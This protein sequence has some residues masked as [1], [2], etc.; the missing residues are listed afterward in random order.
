MDFRTAKHNS[1]IFLCYIWVYIW[2]VQVQIE[3]SG[4]KKI[5]FPEKKKSSG[6]LLFHLSTVGGHNYKS[7]CT[8]REWDEKMPRYSKITFTVKVKWEN[9][10]IDVAVKRPD[11]TCEVQAPSSTP[12]V[13]A[14]SKLLLGIG[15]L[16]FFS[17]LVFYLGMCHGLLQMC[18]RG[19]V[20]FSQQEPAV[21]WKGKERK[22]RLQSALSY[23]N[24]L[25]PLQRD[26]GQFVTSNE[27]LR[28]ELP[29]GLRT[30]FGSFS[31]SLTCLNSRGIVFALEIC[32]DVWA[33]V[34]RSSFSVSDLSLHSVITVTLFS[35]TSR[36]STWRYSIK[37][38]LFI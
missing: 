9:D 4:K 31:F 24:T 25:L 16:S 18:L 21:P 32:Y 22:D 10:P 35:R 34:T 13:W 11:R 19:F 20:F 33:R 37:A 36:L 17:Q 12:A 2:T 38:R 29:G 28:L 6:L 5:S 7:R 23:I 1:S 14:A 26:P 27:W 30:F 8:Q 3:S 15:R